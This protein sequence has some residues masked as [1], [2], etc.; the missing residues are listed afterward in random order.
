MLTNSADRYGLVSRFLHWVMALLILA[1]IGVGAY[2]ADL[3]RE[4]PLRG[5]LYTLHKEIG[6]TI[7]ALAVIRILWIVVARAPVMPAV[8]Q[9]WEVV[10]A[11]STVGLLYLLML[12]TPIAGYLMTNTGGKPVSY[13][14]L[15]DMPVLIGEN[16]DLHKALEDVHGFLAFSILAL[17]GLHVLG[18]LKHRFIDTNAEADVLK[19][20]L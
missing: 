3:A 16:H 17:V 18:A 20:M 13:F 11:K 6:V 1:M 2:M 9:R 8:L 7:L 19:R 12:A 15:F 5:Q 10:L 4:D 14:G